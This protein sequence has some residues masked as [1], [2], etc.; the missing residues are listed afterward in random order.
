MG[1]TIC[2]WP[3]VDDDRGQ[4]FGGSGNEKW[5]TDSEKDAFNAGSVRRLRLLEPL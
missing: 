2:P 4:S 3:Q 5:L 1:G